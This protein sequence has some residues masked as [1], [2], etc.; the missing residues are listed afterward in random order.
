M[1][2]TEYEWCVE[3][4]ST[5]PETGELLVE[6]HDWQESFRDC[7]SCLDGPASV[8]GATGVDLRY[9]I[10]LVR[11]SYRSADEWAYMDMQAMTLPD[12]FS[13][14]LGEIELSKVPTRYHTEVAKASKAKA[15]A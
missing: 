2:M 7:L 1:A 8:V 11:R 3:I 5:D 15:T 14:C 4:H 12:F 9:A 6:D 13:D 10:V